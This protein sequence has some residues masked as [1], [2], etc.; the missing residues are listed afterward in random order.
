MANAPVYKTIQLAP[1]GEGSTTVSLG[2]LIVKLVTR[3]NYSAQCW[4]MDIFDSLGALMLAGVMLVP[5]VD[6]LK[7]YTEL[8]STIGGLALVEITAGDYMSPDLLGVNTML[9]WYPVGVAVEIPV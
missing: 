1:D 5:N 2:S 3:Y 9:L 8:K 6:L 4:S 7:P